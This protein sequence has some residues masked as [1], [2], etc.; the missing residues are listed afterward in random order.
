MKQKPLHLLYLILFITA[1]SGCSKDKDDK[2]GAQNEYLLNSELVA[3]VS[4]ADIKARLPLAAPMIT[5]SVKA[6]KIS[7]KT[8][9]PEGNPINA[10]GLI[11]VPDQSDKDLTLLGFLHGTITTQDEAPSA[12]LPVGNMEAYMGGTVGASLAK[13]YIVVMPDYIGFGDSWQTQHFYQ[14]KASLASACLDMLKAAKEFANE[15]DLETRKEIR[16]LG[17]SEGGYAAMA[18]HQAIQ[19]KAGDW[20]TVEANYPGAGAYDMVGT[21]Q[22]VVSQTEDL[23][24]G[25]TSFYLWTMLT[26]NG[27]YQMNIPLT[28]MIKPNYA[29][30]VNLAISQGNPLAAPLPNNPAELFT[31][32]FIQSIMTGSNAPFMAALQRNN[33]YN[34]KPAAPITLFHAAADKIVPVLNAEK[35]RQTMTALGAQ[36]QFSPLGNIGH[37]EAIQ[38]YLTSV[39]TLLSN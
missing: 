1:L 28:D 38:N 26:Y 20:F 37:R 39:L 14:E 30:A 35:A 16:L 22:W 36:V 19:E 25:A 18:T 7:Y 3:E 5:S 2:Q 8:Q 27:L 29:A 31:P 34:W 10:S 9:F 13:G 24:Q 21:A 12:Y 32:Q 11:I 15:K 33:V 6:Y 23:P 4:L 17:Y